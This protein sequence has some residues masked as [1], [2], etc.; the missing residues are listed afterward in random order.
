[1]R[2]A[3]VFEKMKYLVVFPR[4]L[5]GPDAPISLIVAVGNPLGLAG[6]IDGQNYPEGLPIGC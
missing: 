6:G 5:F 2:Q 4:C 3:Y 1:M